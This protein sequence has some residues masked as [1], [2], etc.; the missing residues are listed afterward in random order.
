MENTD[1]PRIKLNAQLRLI[2]IEL[3]NP[4]AKTL[5]SVE[6]QFEQLVAEYGNKSLTLQ[7]QIAYANFLTFRRER[8]EPA[9]AMLKESLEI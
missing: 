1:E 5:D 9:I 8:P 4:T 7:L 6:K 2:D 3:K